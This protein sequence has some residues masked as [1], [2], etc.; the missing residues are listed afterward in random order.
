MTKIVHAGKAV[1][2]GLFLFAVPSVVVGELYEITQLDPP[3]TNFGNFSRATSINNDGVV[4][5]DGSAMYTTDI[6]C[7]WTPGQPYP[8]QHYFHGY[9][10]TTAS[11]INDLGQYIGF[12]PK[13]D[14]IHGFLISTDLGLGQANDINNSGQVVGWAHDGSYIYKD[15]VFDYL[16]TSYWGSEANAINDSGVAA[17]YWYTNCTQDCTVEI[18]IFRNDSLILIGNPGGNYADA[19]DINNRGQ[20]V[21]W[22]CIGDD[23]PEMRGFI[24]EEGAW[25]VIP[26]LGGTSSEANAINESGVVVGESR[27]TSGPGSAPT[28]IIFDT[29]HGLRDLNALIP[30]GTGWALLAATDINDLGEIVGIGTINGIS[31]GFILTPAVER[32][33]ELQDVNGTPIPY[34]PVTISK[35]MDDPPTYT[36]TLVLVDTTD[37]QGRIKVNRSLRIPGQKMRLEILAHEQPAVKGAAWFKNLYS[38]RLDNM[39][40]DSLGLPSFDTTSLDSIQEIQMKHT[41]IAINLVVSVQWNSELN[42]LSS[43]ENGLRLASNYLYDVTN[44][45]AYLDS[46]RIYDNAE[47][48]NSTDIQIYSSNQEWP[49]AYPADRTLGSGAYSADGVQTLMLPRLFYFNSKPAN[50]E[51]DWTIYPYNWSIALTTFDLDGTGSDSAISRVFCPSRTLMHELGHYLFGFYDEYE[52]LAG[53][54]VWQNFNYG[55]M[56]NQSIPGS[57][58]SSE[59]SSLWQYGWPDKQVNAQWQERGWDCW[60]WF[61]QDMGQLHEGIRCPIVRPDEAGELNNVITGPNDNVLAL[62]YDVGSRLVFPISH[63]A[64]LYTDKVARVQTF[65]GYPVAHAK[66]WIERATGSG[67][68]I[69]DQGRTN[70]DGRIRIVGFQPIDELAADD[71]YINSPEAVSAGLA[72]RPSAVSDIQWNFVQADRP[73]TNDSFV[74]ESRLVDGYFPVVLQL[75]HSDSLSTGFRIDFVNPM[76]DPALW[77]NSDAGSISDIPLLADSV[78]FSAA[79]Y[80]L[81][82]QGTFSLKVRDNSGYDFRIPGSFARTKVTAGTSR[83]VYSANGDARISLDSSATSSG[84]EFVSF[85]S[86]AYPVVRSGLAEEALRVSETHSLSAAPAALFAGAAHL[87]IRYDSDGL[88]DTEEQSVRIFRWDELS[89]SWALQGGTPEIEDDD[90]TASVAEDGTYAAFTTDAPLGVDDRGDGA[91]PYHFGVLQNYP[92]PFNPVTTI[93]YSVPSRTVVTIEIFNVLG[94]RVRTLLNETKSSGSYRIEWNGVDEAGIPV[95]TGMYLYRFSAGELVQTRKMLL[96]K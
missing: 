93:E 10:R 60:N 20:I 85:L 42:Y 79:A 86:T 7:I 57:I 15:G 80:G 16:P 17:G 90:V 5:G 22:Y 48:W 6:M 32:Y 63:N 73:S 30:A 72:I 43:L 96:L 38:V 78:K 31:R 55:M 59:L 81:A 25:T 69:I 61:E 18:C 4:V 58:Q 66:V 14:G 53:T 13:P 95:S 21:G 75:D 56:D 88:T 39:S 94:Q 27:Y 91:L 76:V 29:I 40:F 34:T 52:N 44:G 67:Q 35:V 65:L 28:A 46:V 82:G 1:Y 41:S 9:N 77:F 49:R 64:P 8:D 54:N 47:N 24:W 92:N 87:T 3:S 2:F 11:G 84:L 36:E 51:L 37:D 83:Q 26:T 71:G 12:G 74:L 33:V 68:L 45:Q 62:D 70:A 19:T 23:C 50:R 89:R